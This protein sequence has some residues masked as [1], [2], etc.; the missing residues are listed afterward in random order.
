MYMKNHTC[1]KSKNVFTINYNSLRE[2]NYIYNKTV[3]S[4]HSEWPRTYDP[5][6]NANDCNVNADLNR[7]AIRR[8]VPIVV[9]VRTDHNATHSTWKTDDEWIT[10]Q[11]IHRYRCYLHSVCVFNYHLGI[12]VLILIM[13][14]LS[15]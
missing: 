1:K 12:K 13:T 5:A 9:W 3:H 8:L 10:R 15:W 4:A 6:H 11:W 7:C 14:V 2:N